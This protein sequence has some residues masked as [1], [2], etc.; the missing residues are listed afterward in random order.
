MGY[1]KILIKNSLD[2]ITRPL[3]KKAIFECYRKGIT[4]TAPLG[5]SGDNILLY[6]NEEG[7]RVSVISIR[8]YCGSAELL[9][10]DKKGHFLFYGRYDVNLGLE[11]I[12]EQYYQIFR[13]VK[14]KIEAEIEQV[15]AFN[16]T[17]IECDCG[18]IKGF[19]SLIKVQ[20]E[21]RKELN[22]SA[23]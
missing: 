4:S 3:F 13:L 14:H 16:N 21:K 11:F 18:P 10:T 6:G 5:W 7:H 15:S 22:G 1:N 2:K 23:I 8:N 12:A 19:N 20:E 9:I 17:P